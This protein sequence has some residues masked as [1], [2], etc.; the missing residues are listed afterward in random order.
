LSYLKRNE[1][2]L[3]L[4]TIALIGSGLV[5][6]LLGVDTVRLFG[7]SFYALFISIKYLYEQD[8]P[9][10]KFMN[11]ILALNFLILPLYVDL[12]GISVPAGLYR[13]LLSIIGK[14]SIY[15]K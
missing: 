4:R 14:I 15:L 1:Y 6:T 3:F 10:L 13:L 7:W 9:K 12:N 2:K 11:V 8:N 5:M